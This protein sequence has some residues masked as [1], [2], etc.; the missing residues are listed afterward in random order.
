MSA[1][2][3]AA[4]AAPIAPGPSLRARLRPHAGALALF[5][6][7]AVLVTWPA[8][9]HLGRA[10]PG[11]PTSDAYD[12]YWGYWWFASSLAD[13]RLPLRTDV[14]HWPE[15]GLLWF[16]DPVGAL[17][18]LPFQVLGGV[19]VGYTAAVLLQLWGGMA[20]AYAL[21]WSHVRERGPAVLAGVIFGAS[22]Y[23]LSLVYSGTVEYLNL[24]PL[25]LFWLFLSR[26]LRDGGRRD[27]VL[28]A[29]MWAWA[30]LGN[31]YYAAFCG[32]LFGLGLLVE[33]K[34]G[35]PLLERA[36]SV[37]L[38]F[39]LMA[40][41]ILAVAGWTLSSPDAVVER[42]SAP[43][44][45]YRSLPATDL[46][47]FLH[48]GD[49]Y[50]PDNRKMGNHGIIHVNYLG[51]V[52][53]LAALV[54]A[55][56]VPALRLP[57]AAAM[58]FALGPTLA[59]NG[60]PVFVGRNPVPLPDTLLYLPGSP[61]RLVHHP[62]RLVTLPMLFG[63]LAAAR[64]L[65]GRPRLA[66][67]LAAAVLVE[68]LGVSP[69]A[70]PMPTSSVEVPDVHRALADDDTVEAVWDFPPDYHEGNR[71]YQALATAHGKRIPYGVNQFLPK[72]FASNH[73]VRTLMQCLRKP[74]VATIAR[75]G[76]RPL[77]AFLQRASPAK[78]PAGRAELVKWGYGA[79]VV[80]NRR[81]QPSESTCVEAA[82]GGGD[83]DGDYTLYR[84]RADAK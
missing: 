26:A 68:T 51:W 5:A 67:G 61:F 79:I 70:W 81:L 35:L 43:G 54:G 55:W 50:F 38:A 44:W 36:A 4:E 3:K 77:E 73:L 47:T 6:A 80:H 28:A 75:E 30:T 42:E 37:L 20:A 9:L 19:A 72:A 46:F 2:P 64:A 83:R 23:A 16:V 82:L 40:G 62:Y 84:L 32:L 24:A 71:W 21:A 60:A 33:R 15:G 63:A 31:F 45:S 53:T 29:A 7:V 39:G 25:P 69:A 52:A 59:V 49:Y 58:V 76:G 48:P 27:E 66:V 13:G 11:A 18:S 1:E 74:A 34:Q 14:S 17:L 65:A 22:P 12:H 10:I 57:L 8:V 78:V 56:R 41:P